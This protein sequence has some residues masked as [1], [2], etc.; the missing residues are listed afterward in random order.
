[1]T[2]IVSLTLLTFFL[3]TMF[4][5]LFHMSMAMDMSGGMTEPFLIL[6]IWARVWIGW[7]CLVPI[8]LIVFWLVINPT[9][10][11]KPK[12]FDSWGSKAVLGER[13]WTQRKKNPVPKHHYTLVAILTIIQT[14]GSV[15]LIV[16]LV[17]FDVL[18]TVF[19]MI[20]VYLGKMWFLDRMVWIYEDM[21][22]E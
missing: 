21:V 15:P 3:G 12:G 10:F 1:M 20:V 5:S 4:F 22:R 17:Q 2:K 18:P 16:G 19:G 14:A 7:W 11:K 13:F 8:G 6:A 9:L